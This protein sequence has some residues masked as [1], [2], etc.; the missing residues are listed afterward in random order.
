MTLNTK[1]FFIIC[2]LFCFPFVA[3]AQVVVLNERIIDDRIHVMSFWE[4]EKNE[5]YYK[6]AQF[7]SSY[8]KKFYRNNNCPIYIRVIDFKDYYYVGV[9]NDRKNYTTELIFSIVRESKVGIYL[10]LPDTCIE[11]E[12]VANLLDIGFQNYCMLKD[13]KALRLE[14]MKVNPQ[15]YID[16][17][18]C[19]LPK[20]L[21]KSSL[22]CLLNKKKLRFVHRFKSKNTVVCYPSS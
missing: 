4:K 3:R 15:K 2:L 8:S 19:E 10:T 21:I 9:D 13:C 5:F 1:I 16:E 22:N 11:L 7:A 12:Q 14:Q 17:N 6:V 18:Q 20:L